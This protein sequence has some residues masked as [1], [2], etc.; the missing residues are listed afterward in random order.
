MTTMQDKND[1]PTLSWLPVAFPSVERTTPQTIATRDDTSTLVRT[2]N[3]HM[4]ARIALVIGSDALM[5]ST[6][7]AEAELNPRFVQ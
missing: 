1:A 7:A 5:V 6:K 2:S 3:P 4:T